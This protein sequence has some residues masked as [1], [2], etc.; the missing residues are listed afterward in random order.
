MKPSSPT[1]AA[2]QATLQQRQM[3]R[4][5]ALREG[6]SGARAS[7]SAEERVLVSLW[8]GAMVEDEQNKGGIHCVRSRCF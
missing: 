2:I 4:L 7:G 8:P 1:Q 3:Q 6:Q 5:A